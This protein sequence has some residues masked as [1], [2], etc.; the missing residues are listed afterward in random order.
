MNARL[1]ACQQALT[2]TKQMLDAARHGQWDDLPELQADRQ[3]A[4]TVLEDPVLPVDARAETLYLQQMLDT[5]PALVA[6]VQA[7]RSELSGFLRDLQ[8]GRSMSQAYGQVSV[9]SG[10]Q[11]S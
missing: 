11:K 7:Q 9:L 6:L 5:E 3:A 8:T 1:M 2:L 10:S 4:L